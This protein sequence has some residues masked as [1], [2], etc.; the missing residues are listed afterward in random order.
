MTALVQSHRFTVL[1]T[2]HKEKADPVLFGQSK[3]NG[4]ASARAN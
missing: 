2:K 4:S 3:K 1:S